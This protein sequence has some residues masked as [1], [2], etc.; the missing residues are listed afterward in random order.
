[1][2]TPEERAAVFRHSPTLNRSPFISFIQV[3]GSFGVRHG[4]ITRDEGEAING[5]LD[6]LLSRSKA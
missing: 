6:E 2:L 5:R 1:V 3:I 4:L